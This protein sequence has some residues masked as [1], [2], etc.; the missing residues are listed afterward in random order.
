MQLAT[1]ME[2]IDNNDVE[3]FVRK[4]IEATAAKGSLTSLK[5][6]DIDHEE[7]LYVLRDM[8]S[9]G[10]DTSS[11]T[12]QWVL[13][14]LANHP[15]VQ[16][17]LH[18]EV[19]AVVGADRLP[20]LEDESNMPYTQAVI[21]ETLRRYTLVPLSQFHATLSDTQLGDYIIPAGT[22]VSIVMQNFIVYF[23]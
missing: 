18:E 7:L 10:E 2:D 17:K 9:A 15:E 21:L 14:S 16:M 19:D 13:L 6:A 8:L 23:S 12:I 4:F 5:D 1:C 22:V 11:T 3:S 20:S